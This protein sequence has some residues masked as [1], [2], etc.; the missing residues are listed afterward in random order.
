MLNIDEYK[1]ID[2]ALAD[3]WINNPDKTFIVYKADTLTFGDIYKLV[4]GLAGFLSASGVKK[5]DK[6]CMVLPRVPELVIAFLAAVRIGALPVPVNFTIGKIETASFIRAVKPVATVIHEK[7]LG[8]VDHEILAAACKTI[9]IIGEKRHHPA[10]LIPW[11]T[12]CRPSNVVTRAEGQQPIA[13][14]NYTTGSTSTP[15]GALTTHD[16]IYANTASAVKAMGLTADDVHMC[17]FSSFAHPHELFARALFTGAS[18]ALLEEIN[19]KTMASVIR[20]AKVTAMMGIAPLYD[21]LSSHAENI[22][23]DTLRIAE[24]GGMYT[25]PEISK[26]FYNTFGIPVLSVWGSTE[27]TGIAIANTPLSYRLDG[28]MGR[29]CPY[30]EIK[31]LKENDTEAQ[32]GETGELLFKGPGVISGYMEGSE[33]PLVDGWYYSGDLGFKDRDGFFYFTDRKSGLLKVAGLKVYPMQ[34]ELALLSHPAIKEAAVIGVE[35]KLRGDIPA[36]FVILKE[37][38]LIT[39]GEISRY[40]NKNMAHYMIPRKVKI[41]EELPRIG[42]GK[43]D[44]RQLKQLEG[45]ILSKV[46]IR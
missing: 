4:N 20:S 2:E 18:V 12:A 44:K 24:S 41:V 22:K 39:E 43:V 3:N 23:L 34:V 28:S 37:G 33:L 36:A 29:P 6:V 8:G 42:S 9:I 35:D 31:V 38:S 40:C 17:M 11:D 27:T 32:T 19:P 25:R 45:K 14:L 10:S 7:L 5:D 15:K 21:M 16:N 1:T 46:E 13:Y 30:Y 26:R